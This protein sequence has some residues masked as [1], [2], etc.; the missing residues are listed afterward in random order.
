MI[1][2][3]VRWGL[4]DFWNLPPSSFHYRSGQYKVRSR[5]VLLPK[6]IKANWW[7]RKL[8]N[9]ETVYFLMTPDADFPGWSLAWKWDM[10]Q[11]WEHSWHP[12]PQSLYN[13]RCLCAPTLRGISQEVSRGA[14]QQLP[15]A[16]FMI[17]SGLSGPVRIPLTSV[18]LRKNYHPYSDL[19]CLSSLSLSS[20]HHAEVAVKWGTCSQLSLPPCRDCDI[21]ISCWRTPWFS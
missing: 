17:E 13:G 12:P 15:A 11:V 1:L 2:E 14:S 6:W 21:A 10:T 18:I 20:S 4:E 19:L 3:G 8:S 9:W 5:K 16:P 7:Q